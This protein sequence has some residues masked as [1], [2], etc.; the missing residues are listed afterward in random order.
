MQETVP[1]VDWLAAPHERRA[2]VLRRLG[3]LL[4]RLDDAGCC[5]ARRAHALHVRGDGRRV[6][7]ADVASVQIRTLRTDAARVRELR[8]LLRRLRIDRRPA[9]AASVVRGYLGRRPK[10][11][12]R[13]LLGP[14]LK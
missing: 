9:D 10:S 5:L 12:T 6:V 8:Q 11:A 1:L 14:I 3:R 4:R 2:D 13:R 7:I